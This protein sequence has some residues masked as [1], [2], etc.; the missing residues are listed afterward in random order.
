[1][2]SSVGQN[3]VRV[4]DLFVR[5]FH[6][7]LV[8]AF[9]V[10]YFTEGEPEIVHVWSG[11]TIATLVV[12]RIAWG[13]IGPEHARFANFI[14]SPRE[15]MQYLGGLLRFRAPRHIGHSPA[16]G[17]MTIAL[18]ASLLLTTLAGMALL[19]E[20]E[21]EGPLAPLFA[22]Q[23]SSGAEASGMAMAAAAAV[24]GHEEE[25]EDDGEEDGGKEG[26]EILE[27]I[28]EILANITLFLVILHIAG[29]ILASFAHRENLA[30]AMVTGRKRAE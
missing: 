22:S 5:V 15:V 19:A 16:G 20:E 2:S 4:W 26:E 28:H 18:L 17:A 3:N 27:E 8:I 29:V 9:S 24:T 10:S 30:R 12:L 1:M 23:R 11:Y 21:G 25:A 13:F 14:S 7:I 6:W